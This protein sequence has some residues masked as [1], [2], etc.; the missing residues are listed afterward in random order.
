MVVFSVLMGPVPAR[1]LAP[2]FADL[3]PSARVGGGR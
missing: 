3:R 1:N 2:F